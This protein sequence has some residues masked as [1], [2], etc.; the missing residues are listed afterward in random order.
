[1]IHK[2]YRIVVIISLVFLILLNLVFSNTKTL[3]LETYNVNILK[4]SE[5]LNQD[6]TLNNFMNEE[7]ETTIIFT[8]ENIYFKEIYFEFSL[9]NQDSTDS[10]FSL[11]YCSNTTK[12]LY[13]SNDGSIKIKIPEKRLI[14]KESI[15]SLFFIVT[16]YNNAS[17]GKHIINL[18]TKNDIGNIYDSAFFS[19]NIGEGYFNLLP[20]PISDEQTNFIYFIMI[21]LLL[22]VILIVFILMTFSKK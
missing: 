13:C 3:N 14:E 18:I 1:M 9:A 17:K 19:L 10:D 22:F 4:N 2:S 16:V 12:T 5:R 15:E 7:K 6:P 11:K 8:L 21:L 20:E